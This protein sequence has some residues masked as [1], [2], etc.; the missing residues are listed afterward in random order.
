MAGIVSFGAYIPYY[1]LGR[2]LIAAAWGGRSSGGERS[3]ANRDEDSITMAVEAGVDCLRGMDRSQVDGLFFASTTAPYREKQSA[4]LVAT[5]LDL[6]PDVVTSDFANSLRAGTAAL[7]SALDAVKAGSLGTV[8]VVAADCRLGAPNSPEE[9][10]FGDGAATCLIGAP[11]AIAVE[12][13]C[14]RMQEITDVWRTESDATVKTWEDRW[15]IE[16]GYTEGVSAAV[17]G[18]LQATGLGPSAFA[19]AVLYGPDARSHQGLARGLGFDPRAQLQDPLLTTVG[20]TGAAHALLL[21]AAALEK[22]Q[23]GQRLLLASYGDGADAFSLR[24]EAAIPQNG[25]RGVSGYLASRQSLPTYQK[26]LAFRGLVATPAAE[27]LVGSSATV[28]WRDAPS[29]LRLHGSRCRRCGQE[30]FPIQ[31]VC[32]GCQSKDDYEEIRLSDRQGV[33]F[34]Y[35]LDNLGG[36]AD[37]A[38]LVQSVVDFGHN[39]ARVYTTMTDRDPGQVQAEMPVEM[40]FRR[41]REAAGFHNY[42]WKCRPLR[43]Q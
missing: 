13:S 2:D 42:F 14:S 5:A 33:L 6:R 43:G 24:A 19:R 25:R 28:M 37:E 8:L 22:A 10:G 3:V 1:R 36:Q 26:Y 40:T 12:A 20:N 34:A 38:P 39:G 9:Q 15:V 41:F 30:Q 18:L 21:L 16:H 4:A 17:S 32:Y 7:R 35:S 23:A 27:L 11:G 31:R 29:V